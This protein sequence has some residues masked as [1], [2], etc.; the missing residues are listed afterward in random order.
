M[1]LRNLR[2]DESMCVKTQLG[3]TYGVAPPVLSRPSQKKRGGLGTLLVLF[4]A[5]F[6]AAAAAQTSSTSFADLVTQATTAREQPDVTRAIELYGQAVQLNPKWP[7]GW[8]YLGSLQYGAGSY[9]DARDALSRYI[10]LTPSAGAAMAVRGLCEFETGEYSR[11]LKDIQSGLSLGAANQPRN[12]RILRYHE[13]QLLTRDGRFEEAL[14]GYAYFA[15]AELVEP[16]LPL[17][18]GLAGLR[19]P[20]LPKEV[21]EQRDLYQATGDAALQWMAGD[22]KASSAFQGL[23]RRFPAVA[24]LH[25]LLG[26][27][28]FAADPD[29]SLAE[30]RRELEI[31]PSNSAAQVMLAWGLLMRNHPV[32]ALPYAKKAAETEPSLPAAQLVFGRAL[33]ETGDT[34]GGTEHLEKALQLEPQNLETHLALAKAYSKSGREEDARRERLLCLQITRN[35][36]VSGAHP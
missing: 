9:S 18:V 10:E 5:L 28:M 36:A 1:R 23:F 25:Y 32:E 6:S 34:G 8:W 11:S 21:H 20:L 29:E 15:H 4:F 35:E 26:Y 7:E 27:L 31:A 30:F 17:A 12:E 19:N 2:G 33:L 24:N 22:E 16:E 13:A 14:R 3:K